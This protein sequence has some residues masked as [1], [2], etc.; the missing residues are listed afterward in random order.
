MVSD[1]KK[2]AH[3]GCKIAGEFCF[4]TR[5]FLVLVLLSAS[6]KRFVVSRMRDFFGIGATIENMTFCDSAHQYLCWKEFY[7]RW[8][9]FIE[10]KKSYLIISWNMILLFSIVKRK[11]YC[12]PFCLWDVV[13]FVVLEPA[14]RKWGFSAGQYHHQGK[15]LYVFLV[16]STFTILVRRKLD[17]VG[18]VDNRPSTDKLHHFVRKKK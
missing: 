8:N 3:K 4:T 15:L 9:I 7:S 14:G 13:I 11:L 18:P 16:M 1:L 10:K 2:I 17:G 6:V 5:T 12:L